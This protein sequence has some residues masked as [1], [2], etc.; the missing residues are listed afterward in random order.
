MVT[1]AAAAAASATDVSRCKPTGLVRGTTVH[2]VQPTTCDPNS[3]Q[4]KAKQRTG[5]GDT[6]GEATSQE[7]TEQLTNFTSSSRQT[8]SSRG[9]SAVSCVAAAA[10]ARPEHANMQRYL[11]HTAQLR[12]YRFTPV[13]HQLGLLVL[14][15]GEQQLTLHHQSSCRCCRSLLGLLVTRGVQ[16]LFA[17]HRTQP[18]ED[19]MHCRHEVHDS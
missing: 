13:S 12:G 5:E 19:T 6:N 8:S 4:C 2:C 17:A 1:A 16:D 3:R 15:P 18:C 7:G 9:N 11:A 14:Q 10:A